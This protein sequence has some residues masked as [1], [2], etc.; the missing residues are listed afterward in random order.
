VPRWEGEETAARSSAPPATFVADDA[1]CRQASS[2][3]HFHEGLTRRQFG[4][5][6]LDEYYADVSSDQRLHQVG[7]PLLVMNAYDDPLVS[8][9]T[10]MRA[11]DAARANPQVLFVLTSHGGH[12]GWCDRDEAD[13]GVSWTRQGSDWVERVGLGF[14]ETALGLEDARNQ[15]QCQSVQC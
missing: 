5:D 10:L 14:L 4:Y 1:L 11:I 8:G 12:V 2:I 7:A 6:T 9:P 15:N 13:F 3:H